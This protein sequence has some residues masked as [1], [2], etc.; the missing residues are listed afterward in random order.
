MKKL[1]FFLIFI[2]LSFSGFYIYLFEPYIEVSEKRV[3]TEYIVVDAVYINVTGDASCAKLYKISNKKSNSTKETKEPLFLALPAKMLSP[4]DGVWSYANNSFRLKG[5]E[6]YWIE[7]NILTNK[8][9]QSPNARFDVIS[10]EL[11]TPYNKWLNIGIE[12][13][14][15]EFKESS[16]PISYKMKNDDY[17]PNN[18]EFRSYIDCLN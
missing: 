16:E 5:F 6:Y 7:K 10:W 12:G 11:V 13:G 15:T 8:L 3:S 14:T 9:K 17:N 18:F 1:L 4:E 2:L